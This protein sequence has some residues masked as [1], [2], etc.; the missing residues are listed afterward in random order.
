MGLQ[1]SINR[2]TAAILSGKAPIPNSPAPITPIMEQPYEAPTTPQ[3]AITPQSAPSA[4]SATSQQ[5]NVPAIGTVQNATA[6][7]K[8]NDLPVLN[9]NIPKTDNSDDNSD[10]DEETPAPPQVQTAPVK[11]IS[12]LA[13]ANNQLS[14]DA[15][16]TIKQGEYDPNDTTP[17]LQKIYESTKKKP[18]PLSEDGLKAARIAA[19]LGDT[20]G[21]LAEMVGAHNGAHISKRDNS[22]SNTDSN[23]KKEKD[24]RNLYLQQQ[25]AYDNGDVNAKIRDYEE[26]SG[27]F[28][29]NRAEAIQYVRQSLAAQ[30]QA[31]VEQQKF[32]QW[33]IEQGLK[34]SDSKAKWA[35]AALDYKEKVAHDAALIAAEKE[36]NIRNNTTS[37]TNNARS[38]S[39]SSANNANN[40]KAQKDIHA[41]DNASKEQRVKELSGNGWH[42][43]GVNTAAGVTVVP[44]RVPSLIPVK[45]TNPTNDPLGIK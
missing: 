31:A 32:N 15:L 1:D 10:D 14:Q 22:L 21:S 43:P 39:T 19:S 27:T 35:Q 3:I 33:A 5:S 11:P 18:K 41:S 30:A 6:Q 25:D 44:N 9:K 7:P 20:F 23:D 37:L 45:P 4:P 17:I 8:A 24:L 36:N 12:N 42:Q 13:A 38:N 2:N 28:D 40:I 16:D 34:A 26:Q 29:K